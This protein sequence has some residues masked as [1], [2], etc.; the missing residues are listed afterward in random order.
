MAIHPTAV[1]DPKAE[2]HEDAIVGPFCVVGPDVVLHANAE[3][4]NHATIFEGTTIGEGTIVFPNAVVGSDPQSVHYKGEASKVLIGNNCRIHECVTISKGTKGGNME[5]VIGDGCMIMAYAHVAHD[6]ILDEQVVVCN[7]AQLAGHVKIG[8]KAVLS[9][10]VGIHHFVSVGELSFISAMSGVKQDVPPYMMV[11]G[12][13]SEVRSL[14]V[15]GLKREGFEAEEIKAARD[16]FKLIFH[17]KSR[18]IMDAV[19]EIRETEL[20]SFATVARI[21]EWLERH[22]N[23]A[24]KGRLQEAER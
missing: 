2:I 4:R 24:I 16:A 13:P 14:N 18:P 19:S 22:L 17:D 21:N 23:G 9:G 11:A 7:N 15:V 12:Y 5:T 8:R 6:C 3:L 1:I 20:G 10:M